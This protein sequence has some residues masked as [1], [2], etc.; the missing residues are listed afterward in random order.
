MQDLQP[1]RL[2]MDAMDQT[3]LQWGAGG[4][5]DHYRQS[6]HPEAS[7]VGN[8]QVEDAN[9]LEHR[10]QDPAREEPAMNDGMSLWDVAPPDDLANLAM[11]VGGIEARFNDM[12]RGQY[13]MAD[14]ERAGFHLGPGY[15]GFDD[16]VFR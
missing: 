12:A 1:A 5:Y 7:P 6:E 14:Y 4:L 2:P 8:G 10:T 9:Q 13:P 3:M 15:F 16:L 11:N